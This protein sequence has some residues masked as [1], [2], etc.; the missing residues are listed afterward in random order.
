MCER[1]ARLPVKVPVRLGDRVRVDLAVGSL[2]CSVLFRG[3]CVDEPVDD[4]VRDVD[5]LGAELTG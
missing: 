1:R 3:G 5:A 4:G 2:V